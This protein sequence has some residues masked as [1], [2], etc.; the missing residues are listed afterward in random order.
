MG[1]VISVQINALISKGASISQALDAEL[2]LLAAPS[3]NLVRDLIAEGVSSFA[4][5]FFGTRKVKRPGKKITKAWL[6]S[7]KKKAGEVVIRRYYQQYS[8]WFREVVEFV[9]RISINTS[10]LTYPANTRT[11]L[12][13]INRAEG[14][15]T[16]RTRVR[17]VITALEELRAHSLLP[18]TSSPKQLPA[19]LKLA[20][21]DLPDILR[22]LEISLRR[23]IEHHLSRTASDWWNTC[24]PRDVRILAE[25]RKKRR[26]TIWSWYPPTSTNNMDYLDFSDYR[27]IIM[28]QTNWNQCFK[29]IFSSLS[30]IEAKLS[31][32]EPIRHDIVHSRKLS[33]RA[34]D[35][36]RI[37]SED[38]ETCLKRAENSSSLRGADTNG[39]GV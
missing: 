39:K 36:L 20:E 33:L 32:L 22:K 7:E 29:Q 5:E 31:E 27:K 37:Y 2:G 13:K 38:I 3:E 28:L 34:I 23:S 9:S 21:P 12:R 16:L 14:F 10:Q 6:D 17:H 26:E 15:K 4:V 11:I 24:I 30:F 18:N 35:K 25:S 8:T 19:L 1:T